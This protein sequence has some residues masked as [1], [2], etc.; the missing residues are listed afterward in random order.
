MRLVFAVIVMAV[1]TAQLI[2]AW[3]EIELQG[4][5]AAERA[6]GLAQ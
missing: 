4:R 5:L 2:G 1:A 3:A 6:V